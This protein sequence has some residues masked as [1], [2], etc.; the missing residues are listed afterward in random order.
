[1]LAGPQDVRTETRVALH[2]S[3]WASLAGQTPGA[4]PGFKTHRSGTGQFPAAC[5]QDFPPSST[6]LAFFFGAGRAL[7]LQAVPRTGLAGARHAGLGEQSR[8]RFQHL[9][10]FVLLRLKY[11]MVASQTFKGQGRGKRE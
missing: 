1:M 6:P 9:I 7:P 2:I 10:Q 11:E 3:A 4:A 8:A 5:L